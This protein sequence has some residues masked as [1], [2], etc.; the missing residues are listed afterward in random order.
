MPLPLP[1]LRFNLATR[2]VPVCRLPAV[3][4]ALLDTLPCEAF[5]PAF[6]GQA[7]AT[8]YFDTADFQLRK[9]RAKGAK[10]LTLR[11]RCYRPADGRPEAYA[12]SAKTEYAKWRVEVDPDAAHFLLTTP[13]NLVPFL[14]GDLAA[15]LLEL[16]GE[17]PLL[18]A[19]TV[20]CQRYAVEDDRDRLTLDVDVATDT[21]K[22]LPY[23][24]L[25][26]KNTAQDAAL[27][28]F[29]LAPQLRPVKISKFLWATGV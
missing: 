19:V 29:L 12:L 8:T 22:R 3:A 10:Y 2:A 16:V 27:P 28:G 17:R 5:D 24:V 15:R 20:C 14:P 6:Q 18:P 1:N 4:G 23:A 26:F 7:L 9:A 25:E 21:G 11:L 13:A